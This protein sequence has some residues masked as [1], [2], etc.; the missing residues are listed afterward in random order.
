M[1]AGSGSIKRTWAAQKS[2]RPCKRRAQRRSLCCRASE[3]SQ[4]STLRSVVVHLAVED[5]DTLESLSVES[6]FSQDKLQAAN[7]GDP[8]L[9]AGR[10]LEFVIKVPENMM[11]VSKNRRC[12]L[13]PVEAA[14]SDD[15]QEVVV[16]Q[17]NRQVQQEEQQHLTKEEREQLVQQQMLMHSGPAMRAN[18][19]QTA[20]FFGSAL[21]NVVVAVGVIGLL[22]ALL[23]FR[24]E[25]CRDSDS[26][27]DA[28]TDK[29]RAAAA[30]SRLEDPK[31][32]AEM[33]RRHGRS[34]LDHLDLEHAID[35]AEE[36]YQQQQ[37]A[38]EAAVAAASASASARRAEDQREQ[39]QHARALRQQ[40]ESSADS[41]AAAESPALQTEGALD[42]QQ[43]QQQ[44]ASNGHADHQTS[45]PGVSY[46]Q[47]GSH[48]NG[49]EPPEL[50]HR[51]D[52]SSHR[53]SSTPT[54]HASSS[55]GASAAPAAAAAASTAQ[56][57]AS[58]DSSLS[59][60]SSSSSP[61][62]ESSPSTSPHAASPSSVPTHG[63]GTS[64]HSPQEHPST[65]GSHQDSFRHGPPGGTYQPDPQQGFAPTKPQPHWADL[66]TV[67]FAVNKDGE[68]MNCLIPQDKGQQGDMQQCAMVFQNSDDLAVVL[69]MIRAMTDQ[70]L[71]GVGC[72]P[73]TLLQEAEQSERA[74]AFYRDGVIGHANHLKD[75]VEWMEHVITLSEVLA[76]SDIP[77]IL[78]SRQAQL[79]EEKQKAQQ[80]VTAQAAD[81]AATSI[82]DASDEVGSEVDADV[83]ANADVDLDADKGVQ[84]TGPAS[85]RG[86]NDTAGR[87]EG[88]HREGHNRGVHT[89]GSGQP[90]SSS[91]GASAHKSSHQSV[92]G[93]NV[94][95][96]RANAYAGMHRKEVVRLSKDSLNQLDQTSRI[97]RQDA[98]NPRDASPI[99]ASVPERHVSP[100]QDA[101]SPGDAFSS[102]VLPN[103]KYAESA[104]KN[105]S[106]SNVAS[107]SAANDEAVDISNNGD[108]MTAA[109]GAGAAVSTAPYGGRSSGGYA[110]VG[111]MKQNGLTMGMSSDLDALFAEAGIASDGS[112][113]GS[114]QQEDTR[115]PAEELWKKLS[116]ICVPFVDY[117][118]GDSALITMKLGTSGNV[119]EHMLGFESR[120][121]AEELRYLFQANINETEAMVHIVPMPPGQIAQMATEQDLAVTVYAPGELRLK[122][123]MTIDQLQEAAAEVFENSSVS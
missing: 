64:L 88:G 103:A 42:E 19:V 121:D 52:A 26:D 65:S 63:K 71:T 27:T 46:R 94:H 32:R 38:R 30:G 11:P 69:G 18:V 56:S 104:L 13:V 120:S 84:M 34:F 25:R 72:Y 110:S 118:D 48:S 78:A 105:G 112:S 85:G 35:E 101:S 115:R 62:A 66:E 7:G 8:Y 98:L 51:Y 119:S 109:S 4:S 44:Q 54:S 95:E 41:T 93:D 28:D 89:N 23:T 86:G 123:G 1:L 39:L 60:A 17:E 108:D 47:N 58:D 20:R 24:I 107:P 111:E 73:L 96:A 114:K 113:I 117:R 99:P 122:P 116:H 36:V 21:G 29:D 74:V 90:A 40:E 81:A 83:H 97:P 75:E 57:S 59:H 3:Q 67:Y 37:Q 79:Q 76:P 10:K 68:P 70:S 14:Y 45:G 82:S 53:Q 9:A 16:A 91:N 77:E 12:M 22:W 61:P 2:C 49:S 33:E 6:G 87:R 15:E 80:A 100:N 92:Q 50:P 43:Q 106:S 102:E 55:D 5:G 31:V